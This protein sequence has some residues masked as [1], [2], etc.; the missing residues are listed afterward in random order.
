MSYYDWKVSSS[1]PY[2]KGSGTESVWTL[3]SSPQRWTEGS[4]PVYSVGRKRTK[5]PL[6]IRTLCRSYE[7]PL[8][9][10][11]ISDTNPQD[12]L[13]G[14]T[15]RRTVGLGRGLSVLSKPLL[16]T[17]VVVDRHYC[18]LGRTLVDRLGPVGSLY[19]LLLY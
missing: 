12:R 6:R 10:V 9:L 7:T 19:S 4:H 11:F 16:I 13:S 3:L 1:T 18:S 8:G 2:K 15:P 14:S 5:R 17:G